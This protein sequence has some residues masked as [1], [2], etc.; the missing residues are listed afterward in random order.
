MVFD[1]LAI[2]LLHFVKELR[3]FVKVPFRL[4]FDVEVIW[5]FGIGLNVEKLD[6]L[7]IKID[8]RSINNKVLNSMLD[9]IYFPNGLFLIII[10]H[11]RSLR[12]MFGSI[13]LSIDS[14]IP[15]FI[16]LF[17]KVCKEPFNKLFVF[18]EIKSA[19]ILLLVSENT[20]YLLII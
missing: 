4:I 2:L 8:A 18:G 11:F 12:S 13:T 10:K 14:F 17:I 9:I 3:E 20:D 1:I 16:I 19:L 15:L 7:T 5:L 6:L